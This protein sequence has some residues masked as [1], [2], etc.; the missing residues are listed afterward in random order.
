MCGHD[1]NEVIAKL[2]VLL[3]GELDQEVEAQ[4][5][6]EIKDCPGCLEHYNV[7]K[8]FKDFLQNKLERKCCTEKLKHE[9]LEKIKQDS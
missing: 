1:C 9:I 8:S 3:D 4:L 6:K 2:E 7:D 5:I